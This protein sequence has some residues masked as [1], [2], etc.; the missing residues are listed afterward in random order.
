M[1]IDLVKHAAIAVQATLPT[2][3][4]EIKENFTVYQSQWD[5]LSALTIKERA[6]LGFGPTPI[7]VRSET[8]KDNVA[9]LHTVET[10]GS[11]VIGKVAPQEATAPYGDGRPITQYAADLNAKRQYYDLKR[12][13]AKAN[14]IAKLK[15]EF[16]N[17]FKK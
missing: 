4:D 8:L 3:E 17:S 7:L 6:R 13:E 5:A 10:S 15:Q 11:R 9:A 16:I 12:A 14:V 2:V 1:A